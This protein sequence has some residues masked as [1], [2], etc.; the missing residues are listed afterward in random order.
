MEE[1]A[2]S[3]NGIGTTKSRTRKGKKRSQ[4]EPKEDVENTNPPNDD[5]ADKGLFDRIKDA[6]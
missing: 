4:N 3:F 2:R 1:L 5:T 6:F